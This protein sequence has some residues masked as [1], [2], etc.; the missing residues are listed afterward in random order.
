MRSN[1]SKLEL[2]EQS[3]VLALSSFTFVDG[4]ADGGLVVVNG[5]EG[6]ALVAGDGGVSGE[7]DSEDVTLHG[8]TQGQGGDIQE[9]QVGGGGVGLSGEDGGLD[10]GSVGNSLIGV[11]GLVELSSTEELGDEGLDLGDTG[12]SSDEDDVLDLG[13]GDLGVLEDLLDGLDGGLE[14]NGVDLL[15]SGSGDVGG[16]VNTLRKEIETKKETSV[17]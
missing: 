11:D 12:G 2:S 3:V 9:D 16:E 8:N 7:H 15:E 5:G 4:E 10:G 14:G 1:T 6:S 13:G 17:S